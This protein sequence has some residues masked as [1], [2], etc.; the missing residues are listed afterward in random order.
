MHIITHESLRYIG[1][2]IYLLYFN[3]SIIGMYECMYHYCQKNS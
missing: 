3:F 1:S 2:F